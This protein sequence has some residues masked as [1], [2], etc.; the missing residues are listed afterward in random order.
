M[1]RRRVG[2]GCCCV[3]AADGALMTVDRF[4]IYRDR[5]PSPAD[6]DLIRL[7]YGSRFDADS[8]DR[9]AL[10]IEFDEIGPNGIRLLSELDLRLGRDSFHHPLRPRIAGVH[11]RTVYVNRLLLHRG[12]ALAARIADRTGVDGVVVG[13]AAR[14]LRGD[15]TGLARPF[16]SFDLVVPPSTDRAQLAAAVAAGERLSVVRS[17][18]GAEVIADDYGF[19]YRILFSLEPYAAG[20][21]ETRAE[22]ISLEDR[23]LRVLSAEDDLFQTIWGGMD[24]RQDPG[25]MWLA[26]ALGLLGGQTPIDWPLVVDLAR[27]HGAAEPVAAALGLIAEEGVASPGLIAARTALAE[28]S[29]RWGD[30]MAMRLRTRPRAGVFGLA[31]RLAFTF[32]GESR[33]AGRRPGPRGF[34]AFLAARWG[35]STLGETI[36]AATARLRR[37]ARAGR[38]TPSS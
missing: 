15:E 6:L 28:T 7:V 1:R 14:Y 24:P 13:G 2:V 19:R 5:L 8:F 25:G 10:G 32:L 4:E 12:A 37:H 9:W 16:G 20:E 29:E 34:L 17:V 36:A 35:T 38:G 11:R 18:A 23:G 22:L 26:D 21:I 27:R 31:G 30:R 3:V 33:R